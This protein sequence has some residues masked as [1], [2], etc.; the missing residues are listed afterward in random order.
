MSLRAIFRFENLDSTKDL[1]DRFSGLFKAGIYEGGAV[2]INSSNTAA[3][4]EPFKALTADGMAVISDEEIVVP[5]IPSTTINVWIV[6]EAYYVID[7]NPVMQLKV[8]DREQNI[9]PSIHVKLA[10]KISTTS[11]DYI[12]DG[13]VDK[14]DPISRN[15][16][17]GVL[18]SNEFNS[19][20][21]KFAINDWCFEVSPS[22]VIIKLKLQ[23]GFAYYTSSNVIDNR[24]NNHIQNVID[25]TAGYVTDMGGAGSDGGTPHIM[26]G[27]L[28]VL[29]DGVPRVC[30]IG[31]E[32]FGSFNITSDKWFALNSIKT[33]WT[34]AVAGYDYTSSNYTNSNNLKD[35][36]DVYYVG[37]GTGT[38][39]RGIRFNDV[40]HTS[41]PS[42]D[43]NVNVRYITE[44]YPILPT[45]DEKYA[46]VGNYNNVD[47][48]TNP[49]AVAWFK[50]SIDNRFVT[51]RT[52]ALSIK[53]LSGHS[54]SEA[55]ADGYYYYFIDVNDFI[56]VNS[57]SDI[58]RYFKPT[59][60]YQNDSDKTEY[61]HLV[62]VQGLPITSS[63]LV[64]S[65]N[66]NVP[67]E[68]YGKCLKK[69]IDYAIKSRHK[70]LSVQAYVLTTIG[71]DIP[72]SLF[73]SSDF[74]KTQRISFYGN[75]SEE[76]VLRLDSNEELEFVN[77]K[78]TY[79]VML[80]KQ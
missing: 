7:S 10:K 25:N 28:K 62:T 58:D 72:D 49:D 59:F 51:Q 52:G 42:Q 36:I 26:S 50:P 6:L 41:L 73:P 31:T 21:D 30:D 32:K 23:N 48:L 24:I 43:P 70:I 79:K 18:T 57:L 5:N 17:R 63:Y 11:Y 77:S 55:R 65:S 12:N 20:Q 54:E 69:T 4:V 8:I 67:P 16:Y 46:L 53:T 15:H 38:H 66:T 61:V 44:N 78:G 35:F 14:L 27:D 47:S 22:S 19:Q 76:G 80:I 34:Q 40:E 45:V 39:S 74:Y 9:D 13:C 56:F 75:N 64:N 1:N 29:D 60:D 68:Y 3:I 33:K 2:K 71:N 37:E